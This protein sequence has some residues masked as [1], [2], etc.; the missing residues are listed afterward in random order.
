M[1]LCV[2]KA[3]AKRETKSRRIKNPVKR[4]TPT[5]REN[6]SKSRVESESE[7]SLVGLVVVIY[8]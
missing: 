7:S 3:A 8:I 6:V 5:E 2:K 4:I 1:F